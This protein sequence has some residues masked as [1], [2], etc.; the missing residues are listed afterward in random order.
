VDETYIGGRPR[1]RPTISEDRET[2]QATHKNK[3]GR[4]TDKA[5]VMVLVERNGRS[6]SHPVDNVT[7]DTLKSAI[8]ETVD[9]KSVIVT[10]EWKSYRGIGKDFDGGHLVVNHG[11]GIY[12]VGIVNTNTA[13]SYFAIL[14]RGVH[15]TFHHISKKHLF[16]YCDEFSFRWNY[17]KVNDGERVVMAITGMEG[18]RMRYEG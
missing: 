18:K 2:P 11:E 6:V 16:R 4:G 17:R 8:R 9:K 12:A 14:K 5:P 13:E 7:G 1:K 3:R 10:D 15:G